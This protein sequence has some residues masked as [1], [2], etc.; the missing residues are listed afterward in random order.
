VSSNDAPVI[1]VFTPDTSTN[2]GVLQAVWWANRMEWRAGAGPSGNTVR[3]TANILFTPDKNLLDGQEDHLTVDATLSHHHGGNYTETRFY[4]STGLVVQDN[5]TDVAGYTLN[6]IAGRQC[7]ARP[8]NTARRGVI[9]DVT[10]KIKAGAGV[11]AGDVV[12]L[13]IG[14]WSNAAGTGSPHANVE[15]SVQMQAAPG[16]TTLHSSHVQITVPTE[17]VSANDFFYFAVTNR[18]LSTFD[19]SAGA[20]LVSITEVGGIFV[21][22]D[23]VV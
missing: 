22:I 15:V 19:G 5:N 1:K 8:S 18:T 16:V 23:T 14:F 2:A 17:A 21:P 12:T 11:I 20:Q 6:A 13:R 10:L 7:D 3:S 4:A 9:L